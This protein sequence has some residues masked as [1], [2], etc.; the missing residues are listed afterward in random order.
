MSTQLPIQLSD[1]A[2]E[3]LASAAKAAG[4]TPAEQA[5]AAVEAIYSGAAVNSANP[6]AANRLFEQCFG[7]VDMGRPI[8]IANPAIDADLGNEYGAACN[9]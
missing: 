6:E 1:Q 3:S 4:K 7:S 8:G 5:A 9:S 2:F